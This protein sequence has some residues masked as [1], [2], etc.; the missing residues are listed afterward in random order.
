MTTVPMQHRPQISLRPL[1][2]PTEHG[3]WG[4]LF[5]PLVLGLVVAPSIAGAFIA[6]AALSAFLVRQPLKLAAQDTIRGRHYPRTRYC[7]MFAAGYALAALAA[8]AA[9]VALRGPAIFIPIGL[10]APLGLIQILYDAY[11]RSREALPELAGAAAM[12]SIA[13]AIGIAGGMRV[14]PAFALAGIILARSIPSIVYV[15]ALLKRAHGTAAP[16]WPSLLL[17]AVAIA[18]VATYASWFAVAAMAILLAR[19]AWGLT[20]AVPRAQTVGWREIAWG[21]VTVAL[22]AIGYRVSF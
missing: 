19:G 5:E 22:V 20:H 8:F 11:N 1:A 14:I 9:A 13:A 16:S 6:L 18:A 12:S 4:F 21:T 10:V 2:L 3:G 17:H 15:R 7:W